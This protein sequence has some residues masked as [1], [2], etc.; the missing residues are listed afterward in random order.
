MFPCIYIYFF[1][2]N[3][4][5]IAT[6]FF[7]FFFDTSFFSFFHL[8]CCM[9]IVNRSPWVGWVGWGGVWIL[10]LNLFQ[11]LSAKFLINTKL[12][13]INICVYSF[14]LFAHFFKCKTKIKGEIKRVIRGVRDKHHLKL[15]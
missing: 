8:F 1:F 5:T 11:M 13:Y 3:I 10:G 15:L 6:F 12:L 14:C 4:N 9:K 7:S 2:P